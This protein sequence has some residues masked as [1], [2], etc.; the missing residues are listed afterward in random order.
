M[1]R[2]HTVFRAGRFSFRQ[3]A[4]SVCNIVLCLGVAF[5]S[6][7]AVITGGSKFAGFVI[8]LLVSV[9]I[10]GFVDNVP[11]II[12]MLPVASSLAKNMGLKP[13]LYMFA[14]LVG[15]CLGGNL[16]PFGASANI[17]SMG[18]LK[19]EGY[20]M[21]FAGWLKL[22]V[23]FTVITTAAAGLVLWLLWA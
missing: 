8:I 20:P 14:L 3:S 10:S 16:T 1:Q 5:A 11:Y 12:A 9:A 21:S 7:L 13:E 6:F 2:K 22:G 23:P 15:S 17:V 4:L 19:K 18:I